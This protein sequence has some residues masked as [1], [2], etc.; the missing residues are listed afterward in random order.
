LAGFKLQDFNDAGM[1]D[2]VCPLLRFSVP[3]DEDAAY[4]GSDA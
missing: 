3:L 4:L 2:G 1:A